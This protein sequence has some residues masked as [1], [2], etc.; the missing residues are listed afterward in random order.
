MAR[1]LTHRPCNTKESWGA[2][3]I[4]DIQ[5]SPDSFPVIAVLFHC[6]LPITGGFLMKS[7]LVPCPK[8]ARPGTYL[9]A[10]SQSSSVDYYRCDDC[11]HVWTVPKDERE[12]TT[13]V[14]VA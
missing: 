14:P 2:C 5:K 8:C 10:V 9:K 11:E 7:V 6:S 13:D 3:Q 4:L 12:P 1:A